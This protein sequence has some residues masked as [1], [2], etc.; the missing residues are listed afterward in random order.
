MKGFLFLAVKVLGWAIVLVWTLGFLMGAIMIYPT[1]E[2][3]VLNFGLNLAVKATTGTFMYCWYWLSVVLICVYSVYR[4]FN[5]IGKWERK[6]S[7][8]EIDFDK[9]GKPDLSLIDKK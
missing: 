1:L 6:G 8:E 3:S 7:V 5:F 4:G 9:D 2:S